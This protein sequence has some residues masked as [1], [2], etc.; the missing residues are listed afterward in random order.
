MKSRNLLI[1]AALAIFG[2]VSAEAAI[3]YVVPGNEITGKDGKSWQ[4]AITIWDIYNHEMMQ[5]QHGK[6]MTYFSLQV[7]LTTLQ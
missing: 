7:V 3:Y 4:N 2:S 5:A 1:L 6:T